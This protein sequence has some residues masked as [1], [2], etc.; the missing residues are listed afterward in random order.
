MVHGTKTSFSR[1][2]SHFI[3]SII[4][5]LLGHWHSWLFSFVFNWIGDFL[6]R[7]A[8][9]AAYLSNVY[10]SL[11]L[12]TFFQDKEGASYL[13]P[14]LLRDH[15]STLKA[16]QLTACLVPSGW[17]AKNNKQKATKLFFQHR[18][19]NN[20]RHRSLLH[21]RRCCCCWMSWFRGAMILLSGTINRGHWLHQSSLSELLIAAN[22]AS[23]ACK[24]AAPGRR[25]R[26]KEMH[27]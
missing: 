5:S 2:A 23:F 15:S 24:V 9:Y 6:K 12:L 10:T 26:A 14:P 19:G 3:Q 20:G 25:A 21:A 16:L 22:S 4:C 7:P 17:L 1:H 18:A 8:Y 11:R 27:F 13:T